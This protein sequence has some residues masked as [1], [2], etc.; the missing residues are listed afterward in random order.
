MFSKS[1]GME[2][3][4]ETLAKCAEISVAER[5]S[6]NICKPSSLQA[7]TKSAALTRAICGASNFG[8]D[9]ILG[10]G[11]VTGVGWTKAFGVL[12]D[13]IEVVWNVILPSTQSINGLYRVSQLCPRTTKTE[14]SNNI[15]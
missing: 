13:I 8:G 12:P 3:T 1:T 4:E 9:P 2:G 14:E 7:H 5:S 6:Q 11:A 15:T 10:N